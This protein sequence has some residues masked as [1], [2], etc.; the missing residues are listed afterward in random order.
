MGKV[1]RIILLYLSVMVVCPLVTVYG[2]SSE[3]SVDENAPHQ[4]QVIDLRS[5]E[6]SKPEY[7]LA[8]TRRVHES[9]MPTIMKPF[10]FILSVPLDIAVS[11]F[12]IIGEALAHDH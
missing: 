7:L 1:I 9:S 4:R 8:L 11:P 5:E 10:L 2:A 12:A 3:P 6:T